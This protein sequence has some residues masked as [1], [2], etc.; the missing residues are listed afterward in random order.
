MK[1]TALQVIP[2]LSMPFAENS[3]IVYLEGRDDAVVIDPG[4]EP[5]LILAKLK[6][7]QLHLVAILNTHGHADHIAGNASMKKHFPQATLY[8]GEGDAPM[9]TDPVLNLSRPFGMDIISPPADQLLNEGD[10]ISLAGIDMNIRE[11]PGHS[12]GHIVFVLTDRQPHIVFGGDTLFQGSI[13][14]TDFPNGNHQQLIT[15]I[16]KKLF[17][18]PEDTIVYPGH[19]D[20]TTTG[21]EMVSNPF[22]I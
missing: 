11:I 3:Y 6:K 20:E 13:G 21:E 22:L 14:R 1:Q 17:S 12:P 16:K 19:G 4:L 10:S 9:L 2:V 8:I 5:Q 18:L 15:G 7:H